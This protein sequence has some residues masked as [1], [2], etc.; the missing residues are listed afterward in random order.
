MYDAKQ[1]HSLYDIESFY[2]TLLKLDD[3]VDL[4]P[5]L[6]DAL[7]STTRITRSS[8]VYLEVFDEDGVPALARG[9]ATT[10][11]SLDSIRSQVS[12]GIVQQAIAE[13]R[14]VETCVLVHDPHVVLRDAAISTARCIPLGRVLPAGFVY[15]RTQSSFSA[16][17]RE[18]IDWLARRLARIVYRL[19]DPATPRHRRLAEE[20][21]ELQCRRIR[22][23][24]ERCD[25]NIAEAARDLGVGRAFIYRVLRR[26]LEAPDVS[27]RSIIDE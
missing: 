23:A 15:V 17:D 24:M 1:E 22:E 14:T 13:R 26:D 12:S 18:R 19:G 9:H 27:G 6:T 21:Y 11:T 5:V 20:I 8:L 25:G 7:R 4:D 2:Q 16:L 10:V 3:E